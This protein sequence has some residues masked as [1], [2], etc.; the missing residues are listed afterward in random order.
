MVVSF[1]LILHALERNFNGIES[2]K[3]STL[4]Q[5][6]FRAV[7]LKGLCEENDIPCMI[8][9]PV[10]VVREALDLTKSSITSRYKMIIDESDDDSIMRLLHSEGLLDV[11]KKCLFKLSNMPECKEMEKLQL[12]SGV[13][14]AALQGGIAVLSQTDAVNESF[15][16]LFN[17]N[18]YCL[19]NRKGEELFYANIA[20]GGISRRSRVDSHFHCIVHV[21][22]SDLALLP[23]PFLNRFEKY[24]LG[25]QDILF[26]ILSRT[27]PMKNIILRSQ[28]QVNNLC[29][30]IGTKSFCGFVPGQTLESIFLN[31][32]PTGTRNDSFAGKTESIINDQY[33][34]VSGKS[35]FLVNLIDIIQQNIALLISSEDLMEELRTIIN[36]AKMYFPLRLSNV[37]KELLGQENDMHVVHGMSM[38]TPIGVTSSNIVEVIEGIVQMF[39]TRCAIFELLALATP[40]A[41][42][43]QR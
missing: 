27:I 33:T 28:E 23:A 37:L 8:R 10:D 26:S 35:Q 5:E 15:Y 43:T 4:S 25:V 3:F 39:V 36:I 9:G 38:N 1:E 16:D 14:F 20:V 2:N 11:S 34:W 24:R 42:V 18:F 31:M 6:F 21:R 22:L 32:L 41:L 19:K 40:E 12:V 13:K 7:D 29:S 17:Q 30:K